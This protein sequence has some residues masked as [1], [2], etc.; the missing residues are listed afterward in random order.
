MDKR[1]LKNINNLYKIRSK[2]HKKALWIIYILL[3]SFFAIDLIAT[4]MDIFTYS[5]DVTTYSLQTYTTNGLF[6]AISISIGTLLWYNSF[7]NQHQAF[8][9][10]NK[11][12]FMSYALFNY[13]TL[14]KVSVTSLLLYL[15][16][17]NIWALIGKLN[18]N[19]SFAYPINLPFLISGF[20]VN[21]LYGSMLIALTLL[22]NV[23]SKKFHMYFYITFIMFIVAAFFNNGALFITIGNLFSFWTKEPSLGIFVVKCTITLGILLILS[24]VI[25]S[26][27]V[28]YKAE[29]KNTTKSRFILCGIALFC[30]IIVISLSVFTHNYPYNSNSE[31]GS[32]SINFV[33]D[34]PFK[35]FEEKEIEVALTN[36]NTDIPIEIVTQFNEDEENIFTTR[37]SDSSIEEIYENI[38]VKYHLPCNEVDY[39]NLNYFKNP[40]VT[41]KLEDNKLYI[42]YTYDENQKVILL[43]SYGTMSQF[44]CF[45]GK[46][47]FKSNA[48]HMTGSSDGRIEIIYPK[49][50]KFKN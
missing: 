27:I 10:D 4:L 36:L 28:Y 47:L 8:P 2:E 19:I 37:Y 48:G 38:I 39:I 23:L 15:I 42:N 22:I 24:V 34:N 20:I 40:I 32:D 1:Q 46:T 30:F 3:A 16:Q 11:T 13:I 18:S 21:L 44:D 7:N 43:S 50:T 17:Y 25:N 14:L 9:Q 41:A 31:M 35:N 5:K 6:L 45:K 12:R 29:T 49:G 26:T 33:N